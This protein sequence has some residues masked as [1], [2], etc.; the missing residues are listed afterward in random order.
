MRTSEVA[1]RAGV[2]TETLRYYERRGL[3]TAPPR[4]TGGYRG[5]PAAAVELLRFIKRGQ[6]LGFT[7]DEV[8]ELL[9]L[10][11][12]GPDSCDAARALAERRR[13]DLATRILD[14][15]RMH[16]SLADL[17]ATCD[18]P[19]RGPQLRVAGSDRPPPG[20][21][22][23]KLEVLHVP[24]CP[25]LPPMLERLAEVTDLP[26]TTRVIDSDADAATFRMAG[27]PTLLIDGADPFTAPGQCD[28]GMSCRLYR[29][30]DGRIVPAPSVQQLRDA[31]TAA[32]RLPAP[33][34][35]LSAWRTRALPLNPIEKA[36]HQ[37]ILRTFAT[38][39]HPPTASDLDTL[40]AGSDRHAVQV[41]TALH[42]MDA[43]RLA[44]DGQ[45]VV[46]YPFSATPT[47]H[48]VRIADHVDVHAMCAIDALGISAMLGQDTVIQSV[49]IT[50]GHPVTLTTTAGHT[51]WEPIGAV[52]FIGADAGGGPSADC[53]CDYLNFFA[54]R[55]AGEAW[56][57]THPQIP[58]QI[59]DQ[60]EAEQLGTRLFQPLQAG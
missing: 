31:V 21:G 30:E 47:R 22:P 13:A 45:I 48:R 28:C 39:G 60:D 32:R 42:D 2:N 29:D 52:V 59:L 46:A 55:T 53:C 9:H 40:A 56:T 5:Y 36:V 50:T 38:T 37:A 58:G 1:D 19:P 34:E 23:M 43:I 4:T 20:R 44:T 3:L 17:V 49:D 57:S 26:V 54:D 12:G 10:D 8:E 25:N 11:T 33:A 51:S 7:L 27:S 35:V 14:L 24:D 16:D 6:E 41:L 18:L 15:Q